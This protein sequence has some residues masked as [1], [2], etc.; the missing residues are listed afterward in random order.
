M[1]ASV[2]RRRFLA[3]AG[4]TA[5]LSSVRHALG[6]PIEPPAD[7]ELLCIPIVDFRSS[8]SV[9]P[10]TEGVLTKFA[11]SDNTFTART[12]ADVQRLYVRHGSTEVFARIATR[13]TVAQGLA[14]HG[15]RRGLERAQLARQLGLP[16]NPEL[17]LFAEYG[18]APNYQ[19]PPDF[20]DFPEIR[21]PGPWLSLGLEEM[22][23]ALRQYGTIMARR[24]LDTGVRVVMWDIGNEVEFGIAGVTPRPLFGAEH[25]EPPD[26]VN[27]GIG[28]MTVVRLISTMT[29][30]E[31]IAWC[32]AHL[33]PA[34]GR[35][36]AATADGIRSVDPAARFSTHISTSGQKTPTLHFAF[37]QS[38]KDAGFLPDQFRISF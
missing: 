29:S 30:A 2:T 19:Q 21:L 3:I 13:R 6:A 18:D 20:S 36:L 5:A 24:I 38:M 28:R 26:A 9:S 23:K 25:Y 33:W 37:W 34:M 4:T 1:P 32:E 35:L 31:R 11:L 8:L 22:A 14:D 17:G 16:F 10:F 7:A 27:P 12:V 15:W